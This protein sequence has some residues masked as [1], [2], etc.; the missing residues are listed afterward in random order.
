M[1]ASVVGA[2]CSAMGAI[3]EH[4]EEHM[5]EHNF[6]TDIVWNVGR[7]DNIDFDDVYAR[8]QDFMMESGLRDFFE[9]HGWSVRVDVCR[10]DDTPLRLR[11]VKIDTEAIPINPLHLEDATATILQ[12]AF[13]EIQARIVARRSCM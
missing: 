10:E 5:W 9:G 1:N 2:V 7:D 3:V 12:A 4:A 6:Y 8:W 13:R 11:L